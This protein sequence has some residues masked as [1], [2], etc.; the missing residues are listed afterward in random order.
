MKERK[1]YIYGKHA[2]IEA[3][4]HSPQSIKKVFLSSN[5]DDEELL[6]LIKETGV[7]TSKL[8]GDATLGKDLREA[9]H[10]GV[11]ALVANEG[12]MRPYKEFIKD[13]EIKEDTSL[14]ILGELQDPQ[15]IGAVI[16]SA[17]AFGVSGVLMPSHNQGQATGAVVKVSAGMAFRIPLVTIGNINDT[18][19]DLKKRGFWVYGL[20]GEAETKVT[21]EKF[22]APTVFVLGNEAKGVREKTRDLCDIMLSIPIDQKCESLN[23][24][25]SAAIAL[26]AWSAKHQNAIQ[27]RKLADDSK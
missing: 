6:T 1:T 20:A 17:A 7:P 15:N 9:T 26:Y 13:L 10:Q 22:D 25:A 5:I 18:I 19:R 27:E 21:D 4:A 23:A 3:L 8:S 2:L 16:R 11:V 12:L 14:V 24:A